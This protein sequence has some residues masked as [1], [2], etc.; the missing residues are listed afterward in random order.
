MGLRGEKISHFQIDP[1]K[2]NAYSIHLST[3]LES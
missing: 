1:R 3:K 2:L